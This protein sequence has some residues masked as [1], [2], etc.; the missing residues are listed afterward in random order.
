MFADRKP[1][2]GE[3]IAVIGAGPAGLTYASLVAEGNDVTV[4]EKDK[5]AGGA[6]R[7]AGKAPLFQEVAASE[8][9]FMRYIADLTAA[10]IY[11]GVKFRFETDVADAPDVLAPFDRVVI[12]TGA[13]YRYGLGAVAT[14]MLDWG[15]G[16][17]PG[18]SRLFSAP[19][20]RDWFY[21][22]ARRGTAERFQALAK[23]G[24]TVIAIGDAVTAGKSKPAIAGAFEAAL[25]T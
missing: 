11:G 16:R 5:R 8:A 19:A 20:F 25:L 6:F 23:P 15:A 14:T 1:P 2:R 17:W 21:Y 3:R 9:S 22:R 10:C 18:L 7:Y 12:A 13:R 24:Q 4:F